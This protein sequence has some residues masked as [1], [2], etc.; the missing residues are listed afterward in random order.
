MSVKKH[1]SNE[2]S[3][4]LVEKLP[5]IRNSDEKKESDTYQREAFEHI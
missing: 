1:E 4:E 5:E 2:Y 3:D